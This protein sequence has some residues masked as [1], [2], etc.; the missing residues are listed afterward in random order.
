[1][2]QDKFHDFE[3]SLCYIVSCRQSGSQITQEICWPKKGLCIHLLIFF[4]SD[5]FL[6]TPNQREVVVVVINLF[7]VQLYLMYVL[8][9]FVYTLRFS[10]INC[11]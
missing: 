5:G 1:M 11:F 4:P 9:I 2:R 8:L 10:T 6:T 3:A 7:K